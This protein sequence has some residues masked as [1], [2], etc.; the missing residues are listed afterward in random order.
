M[1]KLLVFLAVMLPIALLTVSCSKDEKDPEQ[2]YKDIINKDW[3]GYM[4]TY[5]KN[6][7][8]WTS[9]DE[10]SFVAIRFEGTSSTA[11][12]GTGYQMEFDSGSMAGDPQDKSTFSWSIANGELHIVYNAGWRNVWIDYNNCRVSSTSFAG[13]MYDHNQHKYDFTFQP[14][15]SIA[16][17]K[18]FN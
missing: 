7:S 3:Q 8:G 17:S 6:G 15:V 13:E 2:V 16:W 10:R 18:Y 9:L 14:G 4:D 5:K 1:K 11:L 12:S